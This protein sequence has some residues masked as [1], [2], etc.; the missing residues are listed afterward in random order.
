MKEVVKV[1]SDLFDLCNNCESAEGRGKDEIYRALN[2]TFD[3]P[4]SLEPSEITAVVKCQN[5][6][7]IVVANTKVTFDNETTSE[8][9]GPIICPA[10]E[11]KK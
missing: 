11:V 5:V 2:P 8:H 4:K 7:D 3:N 9:N 6:V 1:T 10:V